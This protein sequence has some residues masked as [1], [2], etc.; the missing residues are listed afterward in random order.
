[1]K[2]TGKFNVS[3]TKDFRYTFR[4]RLNALPT[5]AALG[6]TKKTRVIVNHSLSTS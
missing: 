5:L 4:V 2:Y 1:M 6:V 3:M